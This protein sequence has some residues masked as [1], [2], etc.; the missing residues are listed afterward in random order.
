VEVGLDGLTFP[1][2]EYMGENK[3]Q[4]GFGVTNKKIS[5]PKPS[6]VSCFFCS[7]FVGR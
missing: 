1:L 3:K 7:V 5:E 6:V 2:L 4:I